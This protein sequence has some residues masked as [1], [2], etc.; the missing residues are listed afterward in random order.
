MHRSLR[1]PCVLVVSL[2]ALASAALADDSHSM[3]VYTAFF[4]AHS[5]T[6]GADDLKNLEMMANLVKGDA[7]YEI[8]V[9]AYTDPVDEDKKDKDLAKSRAE[10]V[11]EYMVAKGVGKDAISVKGI[12][13]EQ[14]F[15]KDD[16]ET[17]RALRRR[18]EVRIRQE[19]EKRSIDTG[20]DKMSDT[21]LQT[22]V[23]FEFDKDGIQ[24]EFKG[25]LKKLGEMLAHNADYHVR[26]F[27]HTDGQGKA[28]YNLALGGRRCDAVM[29][30]LRGAGAMENSVEKVSMGQSETIGAQT[31]AA[32]T[33]RALSRSVEIKVVN[34]SPAPAKSDMK[35]DDKKDKDKGDKK[36]DK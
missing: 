20:L 31:M 26:V 6:L 10:S 25:M 9:V 17:D 28:D 16:S 18:A 1:V 2:L 14:S 36:K 13:D 30:D 29:K 3:I 7:S 4:D 15:G 27:G 12:G 34:L 35:K 22:T 19:G 33:S 24:P 5:S 32:T 21:A 8:R 23:F 11:R